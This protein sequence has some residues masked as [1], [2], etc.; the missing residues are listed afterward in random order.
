MHQPVLDGDVEQSL[1]RKTIATMNAGL[2]I[3]RHFC[4]QLFIQRRPDVPHVLA[5]SRER[6]PVRRLV[7][8]QSATHRINAE[9]EQT[10]ELRMK[11]LQTE[12]IFMQ[13]VPIESLEVSN[14]ENDAMPLG[15]GAVVH[16][17]GFHDG[18]KCVAF[19]AGIPETLQQLVSN[20]GISLS[21]DHFPSKLS[22]LDFVDG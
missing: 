2:G 14:V 4:V 9:R 7:R 18:K 12:N 20:S 8:G 19:P 22:W 5:N 17:L 16:R 10:I 13:Q 15:D 11:A 1:E 21:S 3:C 6:G